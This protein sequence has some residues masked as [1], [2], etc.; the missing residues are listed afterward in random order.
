MIAVAAADTVEI[1]TK[2]T[3]G[4]IT[5]PLPPSVTVIIPTIPSPIDVIPVAP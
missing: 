1:P 4:A 3:D 5:Y 2:D